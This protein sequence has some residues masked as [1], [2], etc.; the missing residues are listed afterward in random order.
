RFHREV[1]Q[2]LQWNTGM[3]RW[4]C[5]NP[6]AQQHVDALLEVYPDAL[7]VWPHRPLGDIYASNVA[8]RS[9]V[10]DTIQGKP[11]D[12]GEQSREQA[13]GTKAAVDRLMASP[14]IDDPRVMHLR[15]QDVVRDPISTIEQIYDRHG[16][17]VSAE[18]RSRLDAWLGDPENS[19]DRYGRY[20]YSYEA[21]GLEEHW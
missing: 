4:A 12:W 21:L 9:V 18:F 5:K 7:C 3:Q 16:L 17:D 11:L 6:S 13:Q 20:P 8:L 1:L 2:H 19:V 14:L 10:F 15:F